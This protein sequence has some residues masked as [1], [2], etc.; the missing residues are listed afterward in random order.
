MIL[1]SNHISSS[2]QTKEINEFGTFAIQAF[3]H[4]KDKIANYT[5]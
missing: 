3:I 1:F 4:Y 2:T 5:K